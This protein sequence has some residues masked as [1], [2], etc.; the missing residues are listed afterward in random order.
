MA[1]P[2]TTLHFVP[3]DVGEP[4]PCMCFRGVDHTLAEFNIPLP[5]NTGPK[6]ATITTE[7]LR[8]FRNAMKDYAMGSG[9][10]AAVLTTG[11]ELM[12]SAISVKESDE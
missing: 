2:S 3:D 7:A 1:A 12:D 5:G 10:I 4:L 9:S 8:L 11:K 6:L